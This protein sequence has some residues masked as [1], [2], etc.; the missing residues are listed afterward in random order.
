MSKVAIGC[1]KSRCMSQRLIYI[2]S[3][4]HVIITDAV[5]DPEYAAASRMRDSFAR[6]GR[7]TKSYTPDLLR[8]RHLHHRHNECHLMIGS[9][10]IIYSLHLKKEIHQMATA[11]EKARQSVLLDAL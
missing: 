6:Q 2:I 4:V 1:P 5:G 7:A 3:H 11:H 8:G 10:Q 9:M